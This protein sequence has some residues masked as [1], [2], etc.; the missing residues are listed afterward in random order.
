MIEKH[1]LVI[2][3]A[4]PA[5]ITAAIY[6]IR[7]QMNFIIVG[8][9]PGGIMTEAFDIENYPGFSR[10]EGNTLTAKMVEH[11]KY[12]GG[13]IINEDVKAVIKEGD[14][15]T[16]KADGNKEYQAKSV[17]LALGTKRNKLEIPGEKELCGK[18][19]SYCA[20]CDGFFFKGKTVAVI[21][22]G[23][24]ALGSAVYLSEIAKKVYLIHRRDEFRADPHWQKR[25]NDANNIEKVMSAN[26]K[27]IIGQDKVEK[28][29]LDKDNKEITADGVFIEIGETPQSSITEGLGLDVDGSGF[30]VIDGVG[31]T[32]KEGIWAAGD[33]TTGS[34]KLRQIITA[35][36]EGA[37]ATVDIYQNLKSNK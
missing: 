20:T 36:A 35:C 4:G 7:Y 24:A 22:G 26:V 5:G 8:R 15:F 14:F 6:A 37:V 29:L 32:S 18:G 34:G 28:L 11:L 21:G 12:L 13:E 33:L 17:L 10:I 31:K 9:L 19:V 1:D 27:E 23:D 30:V 2:V 25:V 3:G 16:V